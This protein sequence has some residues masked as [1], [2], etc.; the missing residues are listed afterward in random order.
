VLRLCTV[1]VISDGTTLLWG[2]QVISITDA[3]S[4]IS[5]L[6]FLALLEYLIVRSID[7]AV[8]KKWCWSSLLL[9]WIILGNALRLLLTFVLYAVMGDAVFER[10]PHFLLGCFFIVIT[11]LLI[12]FS[13]FALS[14]TLVTVFREQDTL[15]A[16]ELLLYPEAA[17]LRISR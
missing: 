11:S 16:M 3:C 6:S 7:T 12:W 17:N 13:S 10:M 9:L 2:T 8:W 5:L 1:Q 4:G 14:K 15:L